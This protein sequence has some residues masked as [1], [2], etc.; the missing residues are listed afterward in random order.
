MEQ[1]ASFTQLNLFL[2]AFGL[3]L[4]LSRPRR[5]NK[6]QRLDEG[7]ANGRTAGTIWRGNETRRAARRSG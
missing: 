4:L 7:L 2:F 5:V 1:I 3:F 6:W